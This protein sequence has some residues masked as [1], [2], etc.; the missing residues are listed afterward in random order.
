MAITIQ[1][2]TEVQQELAA[3]ASKEGINLFSPDTPNRVLRIVLKIDQPPTQT[4]PQPAPGPEKPPVPT[5]IS[6]SASTN[7]PT[8]GR[9]HKRIGPRLLR[10]HRLSCEKG[11]YSDTGKPYQKP[12]GFPVVF[13]DPNGYLVVRDEHSLYTNTYINVGAQVSI[14]GGISKVPGYVRCEHIHG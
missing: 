6:S 14:P 5:N 2:D 4:A 7:P 3:R 10:E 11:Y 12:A 1:I 9:A 8:R 13:F